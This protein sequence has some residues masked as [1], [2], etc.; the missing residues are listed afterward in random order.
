MAP[1]SGA[2]K[3][4]LAESQL[5][6]S[7]RQHDFALVIGVDHYPRFQSLRG[8]AADAA[9]FHGWV[10]E[11]DGGAVD[12]ARAR[13]IVSTPNPAT[14][15]QEQI[16]EALLELIAAADAVGGGR[17]LYFYF[18]GHGAMSPDE[19]ADDVALLLAT[20]SRNLA[21]LAM[22]S[23]GYS[24]ELGSA[25]LFEELT[26]FLDCCRT[27]AVRVVGRAPA[28]TYEMKS[29]RC[30]TRTFVAYATEAG[31]AAFERA[32]GTLWQGAFTRCLLT[33][34]RR[35]SGGIDA[36][37]LKDQLECEVGEGR[38][39]QHAHVINGLIDGAMF[40]RRGVLPKL[41]VTFGRNP[42]RVR[43]LDGAHELVSEYVASPEPWLI[44][45]KAGLYVLVGDS[46]A[47]V[48]VDHGLSEVT[49]VAF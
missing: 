47:R 48:L 28:I 5:P 3:V 19:S 32:Q 30:S 31:R 39:G 27:T 23:R 13:L 18:S 40:G 36:G 17:R 34:L 16:D 9:A 45:V 25:G 42:G 2:K 21:R 15:V 22:S 6:R 33:I 43:L 29:Q 8:A 41:R 1:T 44:P 20:W 38:T 26:I 14:P 4:S 12:P 7:Q 35:S 37:A 24:S 49:D 11:A 46:G 10:C